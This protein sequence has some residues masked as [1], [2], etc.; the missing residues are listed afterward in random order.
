[1]NDSFYKLPR[2]ENNTRIA[3]ALKQPFLGKRDTIK[4][5]HEES[6]IE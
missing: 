6:T 1:M 3:G 2:S 4:H 5:D